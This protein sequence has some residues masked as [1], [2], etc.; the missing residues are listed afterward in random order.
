MGERNWLVGVQLTRALPGPDGLHQPSLHHGGATAIFKGRVDGVVITNPEGKVLSL[1]QS[2]TQLTGYSN[3]DLRGKSLRIL[4]SGKHDNDFYRG[5]WE[6]LR[7]KG[8]WHHEIWN[9]CKDSSVRLHDVSITTVSRQRLQPLHYVA[10]YQEITDRYAEQQTILHQAT[11][12]SL[13]VGLMYMDLNGF[14]AV[15]DTL[16][17]DIGD[18]LLINEVLIISVSIG[19]AR[20]PLP[21]TRY[22]RRCSDAGRRPGDVSQQEEWRAQAGDGRIA[23]ENLFCPHSPI[24]SIPLICSIPSSAAAWPGLDGEHFEAENNENTTSDNLQTIA[25]SCRHF[26]GQSEAKISGGKSRKCNGQGVGNNGFAREAKGDAN[27]KRIDTGDSRDKQNLQETM[28]AG[29]F[30]FRHVI[31]VVVI[32]F[33]THVRTDCNE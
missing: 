31:R 26:L 24:R 6:E 11:H 29:V 5:L 9:H 18:E 33:P 4:R 1:N 14:K 23:Q 16:G 2:F 3:L 28:G 8:S 10:M 30:R 19:I 15:N 12:D 25:E 17:H 13:T 27:T 20:Y 7:R 21:A 32:G 22:Q